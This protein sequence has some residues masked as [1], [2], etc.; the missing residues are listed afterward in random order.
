MGLVGTLLV[1]LHIVTVV[2]GTASWRD[3]KFCKFF[4][5]HGK[6]GIAVS[7]K[8]ILTLYVCGKDSPKVFRSLVQQQENIAAEEEPLKFEFIKSVRLEGWRG[9]P[10]KHVR[11]LAI[12][13][14]WQQHTAF[15]VSFSCALWTDERGTAFRYGWK[16]NVSLL[17]LNYFPMTIE[18]SAV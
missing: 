12:T 11:E 16:R 2:M 18:S 9:R 14:P 5:S 17:V 3:S 8:H 15:L 4:F 6:L 1:L 10:N 13:R 7:L